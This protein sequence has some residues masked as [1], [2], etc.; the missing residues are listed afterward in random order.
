MSRS[1]DKFGPGRT[2]LHGAGIPGGIEPGSPEALR[3][4]A[5]H[6]LYVAPA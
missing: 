2:P 3:Q 4:V 5:E 1:A 6:D